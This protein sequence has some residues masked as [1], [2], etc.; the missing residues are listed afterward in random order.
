MRTARV[1]VAGALVSALAG[2]LALGSQEPQRYYV[3]DAPATKA[4]PGRTARAATLLVTPTTASTFYDIQDIAYSRGPGARAYY[5]YHSWTDRPGRRVT[6]LL[7]TRLERDGSFKA[8][9]ALI[10]GVHGNYV[11]NTHLTEF[12]HDAAAAPGSARVALTAELVD[13]VR[14]VLLARR[15]FDRSAPAAT[16]DAPG[17][18]PAF[19]QAVAALLD[20]VSAWVDATVPR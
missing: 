10:A 11:L 4:A 3:L 17:A 19:N 1:A 7:V 6:E 13:P 16:Y 20:D 12:Y 9:A 15:T 8:V 5:Q 14:R 2:C 18:V